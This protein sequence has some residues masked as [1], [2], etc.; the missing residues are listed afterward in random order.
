MERAGEGKVMVRV[1]V[2]VARNEQP[3]KRRVEEGSS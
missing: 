1:R 3:G 2:Y